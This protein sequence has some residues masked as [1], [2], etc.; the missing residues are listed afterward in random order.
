MRLIAYIF[1]MQREMGKY[2]DGSGGLLACP[3]AA[4]V[5][6]LLCKLTSLHGALAKPALISLYYSIK[7]C[8][9]F[10][11]GIGRNKYDAHVHT[12][13]LKLSAKAAHGDAWHS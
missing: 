4:I 13:K 7:R 3:I 1:G 12:V 8:R 11:E 2:V 5:T 10:R 6:G 9:M